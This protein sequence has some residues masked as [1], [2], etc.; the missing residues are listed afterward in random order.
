VDK[1]LE[2]QKFFGVTSLTTIPSLK[3]YQVAFRRGKTAKRMKTPESVAAWLRIGEKAALDRRCAPF[4]RNR[5]KVCLSTIRSMT[6]KKPEQFQDELHE[7]LAEIGIALVLCPHLPGTGI[8]GA[9]FWMG[10]EKAVVM[11]TLRHKWADVFW[12]SLF[13]ELGHILLHG[14]HTIILEGAEEDPTLKKQEREADRFAAAT[15]LPSKDYQAFLSAKRFYADDIEQFSEKIGIA[16]G[17][18]VGRLQYEG[19]IRND[20]H[21]GLRI[22][23][24]WKA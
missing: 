23:F 17:I 22:R 7:V 21:N 9:T 1:V 18:V 8:N 10:S 16:P 4:D 13:H 14:L 15:L 11:M 12:F 3:R 2:L 24:E 19:H 6:L 5:L 20:W